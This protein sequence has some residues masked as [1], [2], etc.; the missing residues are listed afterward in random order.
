MITSDDFDKIDYRNPKIENFIPDVSA[1]H[2]TPKEVD[3]RLAKI[4]PLICDE[5]GI[6]RM[7]DYPSEGES[8]IFARHIVLFDDIVEFE[9]IIE[10]VAFFRSTHPHTFVATLPEI[11]AQ[12][13]M[14]FMDKID[15][16]YIDTSMIAYAGDNK[17]HMARICWG[18]MID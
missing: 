14:P 2:I 1:I 18:R 9:E 11:M 13:P 15:C 5:N 16:C 3:A 10:T 17:N 4:T 7:F 12:V 8:S 6:L